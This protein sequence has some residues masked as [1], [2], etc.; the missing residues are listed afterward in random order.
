MNPPSTRKDVSSLFGIFIDP[1][2]LKSVESRFTVL[3]PLVAAIKVPTIGIKALPN[4]EPIL[5]EPLE[6][7]I[8]PSLAIIRRPIFAFNSVAPFFPSQRY[9][10]S[11]TNRG[12]H[13]FELEVGIPAVIWAG[14]NG[15]GVVGAFDGEG[16]GIGWTG[17]VEGGS[18]GP[19]EGWGNGWA[20]PIGGSTG[21]G[22][23]RGRGGWGQKGQTTHPISNSLSHLE[24]FSFSNE[25][26][27]LGQTF[28]SLWISMS[29]LEQFMDHPHSFST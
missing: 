9:T 15:G 23:E 19:N 17:V 21:C 11:L 24:H 16:S 3:A 18:G 14:I 1:T 7:K 27:Q 6:T 12:C 25:F 4:C 26:L 5:F 2:L 22:G 29:Q 13:R 28:Q 10:L 20:G 8:T